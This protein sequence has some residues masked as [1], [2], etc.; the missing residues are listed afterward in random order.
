MLAYLFWHQ[1]ATGHSVESY[2][3]ALVAFHRRMRDVGVL[4]LVA[5]G[6][7]R[8]CAG[9][10]RALEPGHRLTAGRGCREIRS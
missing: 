6:T 9:G 8:V 7:A 5:S 3:R 1:P 10:L 2:E 4:G